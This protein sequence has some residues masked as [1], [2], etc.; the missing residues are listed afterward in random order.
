MRIT[1]PKSVCR[2][3]SETTINE[4][5]SCLPNQSMPCQHQHL[6]SPPSYNC[7]SESLPFDAYEGRDVAN[8]GILQG[9]KPLP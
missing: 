2:R 5:I 6:S 8:A 9:N 7:I 3:L 4:P 1:H